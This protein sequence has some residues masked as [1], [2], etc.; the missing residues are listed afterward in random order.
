MFII[1]AVRNFQFSTNYK[2]ED[3]IFEMQVTYA[4]KNKDVIALRAREKV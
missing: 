3:L 4:I 2:F 1:Y